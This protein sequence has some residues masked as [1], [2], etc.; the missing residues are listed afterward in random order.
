MSA[1]IRTLIIAAA[2]L[3]VLGAALVIVLLN[4]PRREQS[5]DNSDLITSN[6]LD[7]LGEDEEQITILTNQSA[8]SV[9]K[10]VVT[11]ENGGYTFDRK[12]RD[13]EYYWETDALGG[14]T[15]DEDAIRRFVGY[16][17]MLGGTLPVEEN[18]SLDGLEKY[19]LKEPIASAVLSF[20]DGTCAEISFGILNPAKTQYVY[21]TIGDGRV[22]GVDYLSVKSVFSDA[23]PFAGL[24]MTEKR[25]EG[26]TG[27]PEYI[28]ITRADGT[29]EL[30]YMSELDAAADNENITVTTQ[31]SYR[32]TEPIRAEVDSSSASWLYNGLVGLEMYECEFLEKS[33]ENLKTCGLD[34]PAVRVEFKYNGKERVLLLGNEITKQTQTST[35][36]CYYAILEDTEGIF[37]LQKNKAAWAGFSLFGSVSRHLVSPYI[38]AC[39]SVEI[40]TPDGAFKFDVN[41]EEKTFSIGGASVNGTEFR[42]LYQKLIRSAGDEL[43]TEDMGGEPYAEVKFSYKDEYSALYGGTS[44]VV[45]FYSLNDRQYAAALNGKT[46]FKVNSVYVDDLIKSVSDLAAQVNN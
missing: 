22:V 21:C 41:G 19:G 23:R 38:Y 3:A 42:K 39:E 32:F 36:Q 1:K 18:V 31:N 5:G 14:V 45:R 28:R 35:V 25:G 27:D 26:V 46:L 7:F 29:Y 43:Y 34:D 30:R 10:L 2:V 4:A 12:K 44:D 24:V 20:E 33:E 6:I 15:P 40:T 11:N 16:L 8:E 37:S 9:V 17:S 13:D